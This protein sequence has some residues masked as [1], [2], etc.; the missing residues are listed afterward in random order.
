MGVWWDG[1][2][3]LFPTLK[4]Q[5]GGMTLSLDKLYKKVE[6]GMTHI[7]GDIT[8]QSRGGLSAGKK[9]SVLRLLHILAITKNMQNIQNRGS[10]NKITWNGDL[11]MECEYIISGKIYI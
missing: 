4:R 3:F 5:L 8:E 2:I 10:V 7:K 9:V 6:T 1:N 11:H